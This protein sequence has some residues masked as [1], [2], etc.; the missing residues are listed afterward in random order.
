MSTERILVHSSIADAFKSQLK[1][2]V[3]KT[4]GAANNC[5]VVITNASAKKNR[6]LVQ[7]ALN[8]GANLVYGNPAVV[9][10]N[11]ESK[12]PPVVLGNVTPDMDIYGTNPF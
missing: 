12:M 1:Q 4:F 8:K 11:V 3:S 5:P 9:D 7:D 6:R 2:A 10:T